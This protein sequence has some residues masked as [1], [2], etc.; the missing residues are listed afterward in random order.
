MMKLMRGLFPL[1]FSSQEICTEREPT[2]TT[3]RLMGC[4]GGSAKLQ[5]NHESYWW[6]WLIKGEVREQTQDVEVDGGQVGAEGVGGP[7]VVGAPV[8]PV[9]VPYEELGEEAGVQLLLLYR[10]PD[11]QRNTKLKVK[12]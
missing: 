7:A 4:S 8:A 3:R 1:N 6:V 9:H 12:P 2:S 10:V 5:C 11:Q